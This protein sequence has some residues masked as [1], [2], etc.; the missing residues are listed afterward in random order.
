MAQAAHQ[1]VPLVLVLALVRRLELLCA[2]ALRERVAPA[3]AVPLLEAARAM[4]N[5]VLF[6]QCRRFVAEHPGSQPLA[7]VPVVSEGSVADARLFG[8]ALASYEDR[9]L[10]IPL[11]DESDLALEGFSVDA[12]VEIVVQAVKQD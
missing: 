3:T 12:L 10:Y 2:R 11:R 5:E 9:A 1:A 8:V 7:V 6:A 4:D